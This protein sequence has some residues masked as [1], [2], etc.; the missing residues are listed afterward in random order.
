MIGISRIRNYLYDRQV[1]TTHSYPYFV[2]SI[3][4]ITWGGTG[5]T[6]LT[7]QIGRFLLDRNYRVAIVSRGYGRKSKGLRLAHGPIANWRDTG[8]EVFLLSRLLPEAS[9]AVSENRR[10]AFEALSSNRPQIVIMDDAFQHRSVAR[11]LDIVLID[12]SEDITRQRLIPFGKA[13]ESLSSLQRADA[14][15]LTHAAHA[16]EATATWI[17]RSFFKPVFH[18]DYVA[19]NR[20]QLQGKKIGA[21]CALGSPRHFFDLLRESGADVVVEVEFRDHHHYTKSDVV[22]LE[23]ICV[24][25]GAEIIV[26]SAKDA[27]KLEALPFELLPLVVAEA[28]LKFEEHEFYEFI[29]KRIHQ[30]GAKS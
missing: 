25:E 30:K 18:A 19:L 14:V 1:L 12:A 24:E 15:V 28:E 7:A 26:T 3:G 23:E 8:D 9:F 4:N 22:K 21:F 20:D 13:R 17:S 2:I 16:N 29:E 11:D 10:G 5:K 27:V 6:A